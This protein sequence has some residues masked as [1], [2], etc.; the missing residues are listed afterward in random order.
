MQDFQRL[1]TGEF[2]KELLKS[3][4]FALDRSGAPKLDGTLYKNLLLAED[5]GRRAFAWHS[6]TGSFEK[7]MI[8]WHKS[9][10]EE[11]EKYLNRLDDKQLQDIA[12]ALFRP[13][14]MNGSL[15]AYWVYRD[16]TPGFGYGL[17]RFLS[18]MLEL[19]IQNKFVRA[20]SSFGTPIDINIMPEYTI[21]NIAPSSPHHCGNFNIC[22]KLGHDVCLENLDG[23]NKQISTDLIIIR[24]GTIPKPLLY[25]RAPV[26]E[27]MTPYSDP[28]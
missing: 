22:R 17:N 13:E 28:N 12:I 15:S 24:H 5:K 7:T 3:L 20:I 8:E 10:N 1:L 2:G 9:Y 16:K 6:L 25:G 26:P 14:A 21:K 18:L 27:Q 4:I 11:V 23:D 19:L